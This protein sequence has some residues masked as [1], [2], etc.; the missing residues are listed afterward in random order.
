MQ[1]IEI[2]KHL[3]VPQYAF[4][5][6]TD[7]ASV[8]KAMAK[9]DGEILGRSTLKVGHLYDQKMCNSFVVLGFGKRGNLSI[10]W[11]SNTN[12]RWR[13]SNDVLTRI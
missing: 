13:R 9:M 12:D 4:L 7:I 1:A 8:V 3:Q 2:K 11:E 5:Q 10:E 6:Y